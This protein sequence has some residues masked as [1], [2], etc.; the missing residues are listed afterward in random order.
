MMRRGSAM[1]EAHRLAPSKATGVRRA[2][3]ISK[4]KAQTRGIAGTS[5]GGATLFSK[6]TAMGQKRRLAA[7]QAMKHRRGAGITKASLQAFRQDRSNA[8]ARAAQVA[9]SK[10]IVKNIKSVT[11]PHPFQAVDFDKKTPH[12]KMTRGMLAGVLRKAR[13]GPATWGNFIHFDLRRNR[14]P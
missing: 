3:I 4:V 1:R 11:R 2:G 5:K 10:T 9:R 6:H 8:F 7:A 13:K 12:G 14:T